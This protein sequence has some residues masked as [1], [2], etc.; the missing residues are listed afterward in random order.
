MPYKF[1]L[2]IKL[3]FAHASLKIYYMC[4]MLKKDAGFSKVGHRPINFTWWIK[5]HYRVKNC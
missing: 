1:M 4:E 5:K 2:H 3:K